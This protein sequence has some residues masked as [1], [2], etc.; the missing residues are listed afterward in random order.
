MD[1][2]PIPV[3][4]YAS[5]VLDDKIYIIGGATKETYH[6]YKPTILV[7]IFSPQTNQWTNGTSLPTG[8]CHARAFVTTGEFAAK[9]I[10]V[11]G[12][13]FSSYYRYQFSAVTNLTQVYNPQT[14]KW[15]TANPMPTAR[16]YFGN[17]VVNDEL[18][19]IG[20]RNSDETEGLVTNEKYT[21]TDYIPEFSL[22]VIILPFIVI[23]M[24]VALIYRKRLID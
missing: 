6:D 5:A 20:G 17:V 16:C 8:V 11:V 19:A 12:G 15:T 23:I 21:P 13:S 14:N 2:I 18:Y 4:G 22:W 1:P 7:Q 10:Y 24:V 9:Q 3:M